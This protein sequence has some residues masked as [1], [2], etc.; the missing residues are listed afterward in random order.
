MSEERP[1]VLP[2]AP[3]GEVFKKFLSPRVYFTEINGRARRGEFWAAA[4][5]ALIPT[6]I[7]GFVA[8]YLALSMGSLALYAI[9][10]LP[11][12][13]VGFLMLP[14]TI[15]RWHDLG[16]TGWVAIITMGVTGFPC[17]AIP[18]LGSILGFLASITCLVFFCLA[19]RKGDNAY[20]ADPCDLNAVEPAES[21]KE[22]WMPLI[23]VGGIMTLVN[24]LWSIYSIHV[25]LKAMNSLKSL[26]SF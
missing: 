16:A 17:S 18:V 9:L 2:A 10:S 22:P 20:G 4:L 5:M 26:F 21:R 12:A 11:I 15:R 25:T 19:G 14:V 8:S 6:I 23:L 1:A 24:W 7:L 13:L 3:F